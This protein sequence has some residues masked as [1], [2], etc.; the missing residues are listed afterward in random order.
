MKTALVVGGT[1][2]VGLAVAD[3]LSMH[4]IVTVAA[5]KQ[6][7]GPWEFE[8]CDITDKGD[9]SLLASFYSHI[10]ALVITVGGFDGDPM[11]SNCDGPVALAEAFEGKCGSVTFVSSTAVRGK[12]TPYSMAKRKLESFVSNREWMPKTRVNAVRPCAID[13]GHACPLPEDGS[14]I[15]SVDEVA[16]AISLLVRNEAINRVVLPVDRGVN[17]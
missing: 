8:R 3:F 16:D 4:Y 5:R 17:L 11:L 12:P 1:S 6:G 15:V 13:G 10:D 14:P 9:R 2:G 7:Y